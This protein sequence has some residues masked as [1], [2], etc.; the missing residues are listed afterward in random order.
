ML[1]Y[2]V[3]R[4]RKGSGRGVG[5]GERLGMVLGLGLFGR[6]T[7]KENLGSERKKAPLVK[8]E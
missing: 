8:G 3:V 6:G 2:Y 7:G 5:V 1:L 4:V